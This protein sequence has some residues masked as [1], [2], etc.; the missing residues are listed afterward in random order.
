VL[1]YVGETALSGLP[2][3]SAASSKPNM[4]NWRS[5]FFCVEFF[6]FEGVVVVSSASQFEDFVEAPAA[7][8]NHNAFGSAFHRHNFSLNPL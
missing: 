6:A 2:R 7:T 3:F 8:Q 4:L 1:K 5:V